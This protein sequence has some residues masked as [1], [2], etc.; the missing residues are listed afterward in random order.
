MQKQAPTLG[1]LLVMVGFALSC[2]GLLLFLWLAFGGPVPLKPKGYRF[3][4]QFTSGTQLA[5][6][7]DVRISG[8]S[9]GKVKTITPNKKT[10]RSDVVVELQSRYAPIPRN[11]KAILRQKTLLGETYVELTPGNRRAGSIPENGTLPFGQVSPGVQLDQIYRTFDPRTRAAFQD[12]MGQLAVA[13]A[14]RGRDISDAIG[15]LAPFAQDTN[16]LLEILDEQAP[17]VRNLISNTGV[18]FD[19][20]SQRDD[21]LRNL[22]TSSNR[23]FATTASRDQALKAAFVALP[24]FEKE[25]KTTLARLTRFSNNANPVVTALRPAARQLSPTLQSLASLA[26]D[27]KSLFR[28]LD[29]AITASKRGLP[30]LERFT[31]ELHPLLGEFDPVLSQLNPILDFT[32][33]YKD[34]LRAFFANTVA[35]TEATNNV[36][37]PSGKSLKVHYLRTTNPQNPENLALYPRRIGSNRPNP[38][39]FPD[40]F[41]QLAQ[42]MAQYETRQC[43]AGEPTLAQTTVDNVLSLAPQPL[44][45]IVGKPADQVVQDIQQFVFGGGPNGAVP[46]PPCK[47]Q[48]DFAYQGHRSRFPQVGPGTAPSTL[49]PA[50]G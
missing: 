10:G 9:V 32:G 24:T 36:L 37:S 3:H 28:N 19:A 20:L 8:V 47:L 35:A 23:V 1:R 7:A 45:S 44:A 49:A 6:E 43:G 38:Y 14:G 25:S 22:I 11:S 48:P 18:V 40:S 15:N 17:S 16:Q 13:S 2:F 41:A 29:P 39:P 34:E 26:P 21:Q 5:Q 30:A 33:N 12:W 46:A 50:G 42:G 27:L 31:D 4:V